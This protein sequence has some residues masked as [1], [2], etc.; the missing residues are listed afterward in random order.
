MDF[1][2]GPLVFLRELLRELR[3]KSLEVKYGVERTGEALDYSLL[4]NFD[5]AGFG[6]SSF[7]GPVI[8]QVQS[9]AVFV[10]RLQAEHT[11]PVGGEGGGNQAAEVFE[12]LPF[13]TVLRIDHPN[14]AADVG[15]NLP[16]RQVFAIRAESQPLRIEFGVM[17]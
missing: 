15:R 13:F 1:H 6:D 4:V 9:Q 3:P 12:G 17:R 14:D 7:S 2:L 11:L 5:V 8:P 10:V 16:E